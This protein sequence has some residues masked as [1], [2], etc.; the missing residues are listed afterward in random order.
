M[1]LSHERDVSEEDQNALI[2]ENDS[3]TMSSHTADELLA[4][5]TGFIKN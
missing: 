3:D 1:S 4:P 5:E 2:S